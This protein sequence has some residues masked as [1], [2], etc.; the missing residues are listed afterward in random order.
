MQAIAKTYG[1]AV[2]VD[3]NTKDLIKDE[4]H[5][6]EVD[7]INHGD[8]V[9]MRLIEIM[10]SVNDKPNHDMMTTI[11]SYELG[12]AEYKSKNY[13]AAIMHF[14]KS[15]ALTDDYPSK[16]MIE[17]CRGL[18]DGRLHVPEEDWDGRWDLKI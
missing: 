5:I 17:R 8:H 7:V 1:A 18:I 3:A 9:G 16:F 11:I 14:K 13:Q 10:A 4:Y 2:L 15:Q 12:L 6:R